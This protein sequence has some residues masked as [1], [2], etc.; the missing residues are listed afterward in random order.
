MEIPSFLQS[1]PPLSL[2]DISFVYV[3]LPLSLF[4]YYVAPRRARPAA[5]ALISLGYCFLAQP[6]SLPLLCVSVL[7]DFGAARVMAL[8]DRDDTLRRICMGFSVLK[9]LLVI[10]LAGA[11][12]ETGRT[13]AALGVVI[14][15]ASTLDAVRAFY[16]RECPCEK[17]L[18]VFALHG[19]F[20]PKLYAGPM[21]PYK[22]YAGQLAGIH[23]QPRSLWLGI[24]QFAQ[25]GLKVLLLGRQILG[26]Y[27]TAA[28]FGTEE[29]SVLSVWGAMLFFALALYYTLSGYCE[30]AQGIG[31]AFGL[32][33][34][35]NYYY[36]YQSRN[37]S[38]F[39]ERFQSTAVSLIRRCTGAPP[40]GKSGILTDTVYV[41]LTGVLAGLWFGFRVNYLLWG[42]FLMCFAVLERQV[43]S[44]WGLQLPTLLGRAVT[45]LL[46]LVSFAVMA[47][48][49]A[50][51]SLLL[52]R[53]ML[54]QGGLPLYDGRILYLITSNWLLLVSGA[55]LCANGVNLCM[56]WL[57]KNL[58]RVAGF[59]LITGN[60]AILVVYTAIIL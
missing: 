33:L 60:A 47:G 42:V 39:F 26:L 52:L 58:P 54:G 16:K 17:N 15:C 48:G 31:V 36:P 38:D 8:C 6:W 14:C 20:F 5:L 57:H 59:V 55:F 10:V 12:F 40:P 37:V 19:L 7:L 49:S 53:R 18:A 24:G 22:D 3:F 23:F 44:R 45:L 43:F 34:P 32:F 27:R 21:Q 29:M 35:R 1:W 11:F 28:A 41:L 30:M 4:C 46:V 56:L 51:E 13:P 50:G 9:N 2:T 25:G